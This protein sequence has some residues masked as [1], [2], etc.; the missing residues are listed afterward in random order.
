MRKVIR[1]E[2]QG[3]TK[4]VR[5]MRADY[6]VHISVMTLKALL[7]QIPVQVQAVGEQDA[8]C[9]AVSNHLETVWTDSLT[10][11]ENTLYYGR[12]AYELVYGFDQANWINCVRK[13][14][15]LPFENTKL[16]LQDGDPN[17]IT[18]TV[19][20]E[21]GKDQSIHVPQ[22][23]SWWQSIGAT[24]IQ[25]HGVPIINGSP[26][27][28]W[29]RRQ[30]QI[31]RIEDFCTRFAYD[32]G[33]FQTPLFARD[34]M[35]RE[36]DVGDI[37]NKEMQRKG[38]GGCLLLPFDW[39]PVTNQNKYREI[40]APTSQSPQPLIDVL[41]AFDIQQLRSFGISEKTI[42]EGSQMGSWASATVQ[43]LVLYAVVESL[44]KGLIWTFK[45]DVV[46]PVT[47][48]N[49]NGTGWTPTFDVV[50]VPLAKRNDSLVLQVL[51][52]A[53]TKPDLSPAIISELLDLPKIL[54]TFN[55][56]L[57]PDTE[58]KMAEMVALAKAR[59]LKQSGDG[60]GGNPTAAAQRSP[61]PTP[62]LSPMADS[63][64]SLLG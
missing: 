45:R 55:F 7:C 3:I 64:F 62:T 30:A 12:T 8:R 34:A 10:N 53:L 44:L 11:V 27:E 47:A 35:N 41:S 46:P 33:I 6:Q 51:G 28:V 54:R 4:A 13:C 19:K 39:D 52:D 1:S 9:A 59:Y 18:L 24:N 17:G 56:D 14:V 61:T 48:L 58:A 23:K 60:E 32:G 36:I 57:N 20:N 29:A 37:F 31:D 5:D 49:W 40:R 63:L 50:Y 15:D 26:K 2:D 21:A 22:Y 42:T 43:M 38:P 25:P 16:E